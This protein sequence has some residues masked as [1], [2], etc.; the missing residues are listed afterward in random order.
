MPNPKLTAGKIMK[1]LQK[2]NEKTCNKAKISK[3]LK[4]A[5]YELFSNM[6]TSLAFALA[7]LEHPLYYETSLLHIRIGTNKIMEQNR[8]K[9]ESC[10]KKL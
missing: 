3:L 10:N 7:N 4:K 1:K 2:I 9:R 8:V 5:F 6:P